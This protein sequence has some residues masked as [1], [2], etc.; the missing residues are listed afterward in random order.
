VTD[1]LELRALEDEQFPTPRFATRTQAEAVQ[2]EARQG[3][4]VP[5]LSGER[6]EVRVMVLYTDQ[7][8]A[9]GLREPRTREVGVE[10]MRNDDRRHLEG[11]PQ[12]V[13]GLSQETARRDVLDVADVLADER[14][15]TAGEAHGVLQV[16]TPDARIGLGSRG[17]EYEWLIHF[18][19]A[20]ES[21]RGEQ[22]ADQFNGE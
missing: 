22:H 13:D 8:Q 4:S 12:V 1:A 17:K 15:L 9:D 11:L 6:R 21:P 7:R 2:R 14:L 16:R 3:S 19:A 18:A 5:I 10:V 20:K